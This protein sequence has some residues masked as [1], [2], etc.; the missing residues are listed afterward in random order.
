MS[1]ADD[2]LAALAALSEPT[3]WS[4]PHAGGRGSAVCGRREHGRC[5]GARRQPSKRLS[6][7][8]LLQHCAELLADQGYEPR[9]EGSAITLRN[10]PFHA[11]T[12]QHRQLVCGMNLELIRG[13]LEAAGVPEAIARLDPAP[14]RCCVSLQS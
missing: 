5:I 13:V 1:T 4:R 7:R 3:R 6:R 2:R 10:C 14:G 12:E 11:L 8:Q 9:G